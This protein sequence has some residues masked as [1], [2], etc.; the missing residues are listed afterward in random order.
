MCEVPGC[1]KRFTEYSSLYKH[2]IVH[3]QHKPYTCSICQKTYRQTSTLAMHKRTAHGS[4]DFTETEKEGSDIF[5]PLGCLDK[6]IKL[7]IIM[8]KQ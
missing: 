6:T 4:D 7:I 8:V 3:T 2:N 1:L 5:Y